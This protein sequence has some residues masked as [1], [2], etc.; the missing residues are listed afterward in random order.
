MPSGTT[1]PAGALRA[2]AR[3]VASV[4]GRGADP[5]SLGMLSVAH[6]IERRADELEAVAGPVDAYTTTD[7][8]RECAQAT[9]DWKERCSHMR[10][11]CVAALNQVLSILH[12]LDCPLDVRVTMAHDRAHE[13]LRNMLAGPADA[14]KEDTHMSHGSTVPGN[15]QGQS[16]IA[17]TGCVWSMDDVGGDSMWETQCKNAFYFEGEGTAGPLDAGF[18]VCPYCAGALSESRTSAAIMEGK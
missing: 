8:L 11:D 17:A 5:H 7:A 15:T 14:P 10:E 18:T 1:G 6:F 3:E 4:V 9:W 13:S 2:I 16:P 12:D